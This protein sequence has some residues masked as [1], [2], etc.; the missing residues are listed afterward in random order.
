MKMSRHTAKLLLAALILLPI[1]LLIV[2]SIVEPE[3]GAGRGRPPF[4]YT[5]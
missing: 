2:R 1:T 3:L 4:S 5:P